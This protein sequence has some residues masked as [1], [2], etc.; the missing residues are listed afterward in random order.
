MKLLIASIGFV[1]LLT[2]NAAALAESDKVV[3]VAYA[4]EVSGKV[5]AEDLEGKRHLVKQD[6]VFTEGMNLIVLEKS[7]IS[8]HYAAAGCDVSYT[9]GT[10]VTI[11]ETVPCATGQEMA[12]GQAVNG[13]RKF[14]GSRKLGSF[15]GA[16][17]LTFVL[18]VLILTAAVVDE[19][20]SR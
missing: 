11:S 2:L 20:A 5:L 9:S 12:T 17:A 13:S 8:L 3:P 7:S 1:G 16:G 18:P 15:T 4:S 10:L 6:A 19:P 14:N